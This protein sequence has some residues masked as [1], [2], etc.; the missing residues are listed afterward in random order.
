MLAGIQLIFNPKL[1]FEHCKWLF[2]G[3]LVLGVKLFRNSTHSNY[4]IINHFVSFKAI[5]QPEQG[6]LFKTF[7]NE[8]FTL[9][10]HH[11]YCWKQTKLFN[12]TAIIIDKHKN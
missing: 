6:P 2:D 11:Y 5:K 12:F 4:N 8:Y 9:K 3:M 7:W 10:S 1:L